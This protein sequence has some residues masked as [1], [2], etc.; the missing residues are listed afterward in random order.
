MTKNAL[1]PE[2]FQKLLIACANLPFIRPNRWATDYVVDMLP[3]V[4]DFHMQAPVVDDAIT[5]FREQ[6]QAQHAIT[7]HSQL[8][9]VLSAYPDTEEG[10]KAASQF[11]W[12]NNHWPRVGFL[13][14]ILILFA[15]IN[16]TDQPALRAWAKQAQFERDFKGK[17]KGLGVAVFH[18][19]LIRCGA[20]T[21]K[22]DVWV[23]KFTQRVTGKRLSEKALVD[24]FSKIAPLI[25]ETL[26]TIDVTIWHYERMGMAEDVPELRVVFWTLLKQELDALLKAAAESTE[27]TVLSDCTWQLVLDPKPLLRYDEAGLTMTPDRSLFGIDHPGITTVAIRQSLWSLGLKL[28]IVVRHETPL[29]LPLFEELQERL[30]LKEEPGG[31]PVW[32]TSNDPAFKAVLDAEDDLMMP[33]EMTED[34]LHKWAREMVG[35]MLSRMKGL[36]E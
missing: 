29:S 20:D 30:K 3:T 14:Q 18:W 32:E 24:V 16:V 5:Y 34:E 6:V 23:I 35:Q 36:R 26:E 11:L 12:S 22:P 31:E 4:L 9:A 13:R 21:I 8:E 19:L 33:P 27:P 17:V 25:G 28:E 1:T 2:Q 15:S 10:N 7:T